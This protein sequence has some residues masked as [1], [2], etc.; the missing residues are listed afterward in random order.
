[1]F[2]APGQVVLEASGGH[3][4]TEARTDTL[5]PSVPLD[6]G[7]GHRPIGES[8]HSGMPCSRSASLS[9]AA[10]DC[11]IAAIRSPN[12]LALTIREINFSRTPFPAHDCLIR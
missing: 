7:S 4:H 6:R 9:R 10:R 8:S 3:D 11:P 1:M 2:F 5:A 12:T